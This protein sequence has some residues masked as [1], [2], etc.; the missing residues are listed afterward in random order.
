MNP[1]SAQACLVARRVSDGTAAVTKVSLRSR[2][3][4]RGNP[5]ASRP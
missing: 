5:I 2:A 3:G 1:F 4:L